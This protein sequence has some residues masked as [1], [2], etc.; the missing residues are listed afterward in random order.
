M[1]YMLHVSKHELIPLKITL[2]ITLLVTLISS[3]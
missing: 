2:F 1:F 3:F